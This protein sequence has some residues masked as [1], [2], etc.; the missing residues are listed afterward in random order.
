MEDYITRKIKRKTKNKYTYSYVDSDGNKVK[1]KLVTNCLNDLYIPPAHDDVKINLD[2]D[3]KIR[4]IG[5]DTKGRA[6]YVYNKKF[7]EKRSKNKFKHML[8]FG[9][10]YKK[11]IK[12]IN[13]DLYTDKESKNKQIAAI[14]KIVIEC[15]FR[16]GNDKYSRENKSYGVTTL[17]NR[18]VKVG[19]DNITIDFIGKKGVRNTCKLRNKKLSKN[20]R[21]KKKI[22]SKN[23]RIFT[24]RVKNK[25]Y[26]VNSSDVNKYL[27]QF[28]NFTAKNFRTWSANI[29]FISEIL[30]EVRVETETKKKKVVTEVLKKVADK[31]HNTPSVCR[32]NYIDPYLIETYMDDT[33]RF[34]ATFRDSTSKEDITDGYLELLKNKI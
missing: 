9:E 14:L 16:I 2:T 20:L 33:K 32:S 26:N 4:A 7:K 3:N 12:Q 5:Y 11:I 30:K 34:Y 17:E 29:E 27:K 15:N 8:K 6:Q 28:G 31:L 1:D 18:H 25:Y 13:K 24:Y 19:K 23:D 22:L 10:S 21:T